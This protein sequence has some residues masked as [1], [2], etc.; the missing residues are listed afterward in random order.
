MMQV[1]F[2]A[3]IMNDSPDEGILILDAYVKGTKPKVLFGKRIKI[4]P[5][6]T[7]MS[8]NIFVFCTPVVGEGGKDF[9]GKVILIDQLKREHPTDKITFTWVGSTEPPPPPDSSVESVR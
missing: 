3:D 7:V 9:T 6:T 8:E 5:T 4:P 2:T 1:R